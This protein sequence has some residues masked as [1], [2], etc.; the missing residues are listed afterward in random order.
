MGRQNHAEPL[1]VPGTYID[2]LGVRFIEC[3]PDE[4]PKV[5]VSS[6]CQSLRRINWDAGNRRKP[7]ARPGFTLAS[8]STEHSGREEIIFLCEGQT[9]SWHSAILRQG[10]TGGNVLEQ[11]RR[12][13]VNAV[14]SVSVCNSCCVKLLWTWESSSTY[15]LLGP[16]VRS[17]NTPP[18]ASVKVP[19]G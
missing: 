6:D 10:R 12:Q 15:Y 8:R 7:R 4:W 1:G 18:W 5:G 17:Q 2:G 13:V 14:R 9:D 11:P 19:Q 3:Y 16:E